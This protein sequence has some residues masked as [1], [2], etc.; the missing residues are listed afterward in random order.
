[1]KKIFKLEFKK[2]T[3]SIKKILFLVFF[4][5]FLS[6]SIFSFEQMVKGW[7]TRIQ[8]F[9]DVLCVLRH[10]FTSIILKFY[11]HAIVIILTSKKFEHWFE[12]NIDLKMAENKVIT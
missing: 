3:S 8:T 12:A 5:F 6:I 2:L 11:Y 7:K 1:M 4:F 9:T 10:S